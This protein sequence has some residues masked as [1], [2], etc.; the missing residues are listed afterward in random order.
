MSNTPNTA[1]ERIEWRFKKVMKYA[2]AMC[3][4]DDEER[5]YFEGMASMHI[6]RGVA[7]V[8]EL[9]RETVALRAEVERLRSA[10]QTEKE[11][12]RVALRNLLIM[13]PHCDT[14]AVNSKD[15]I[16]VGFCNVRWIDIA[17]GHAALATTEAKP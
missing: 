13:L 16:P 2:V 6:D 12:L 1:A 10:F 15:R 8:E 11:K 3:S 5:R 7:Q 4:E 14:H 17:E 9:E